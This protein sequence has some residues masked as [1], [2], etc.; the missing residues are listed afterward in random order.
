MVEERGLEIT[1]RVARSFG[2]TDEFKYIRIADQLPIFG[3]ESRLP[4]VGLVL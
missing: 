3:G 2:K 1:F 4:V